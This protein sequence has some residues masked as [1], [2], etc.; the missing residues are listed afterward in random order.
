MET[1]SADAGEPRPEPEA[2]PPESEAAPAPEAG[3]APAPLPSPPTAPQTA[4]SNLY[5]DPR[6]AGWFQSLTIAS[7]A[8]GQYAYALTI[9][10]NI[11]TTLTPMTFSKPLFDGIQWDFA[12]DK[13]TATLLLSRI[14]DAGVSGANPQQ[15]TDNTNLIG[16]RLV[17]QV[18]DFVKVGGTFVSA[19]HAHTQV[20][21]FSGDMFK[22]NLTT[23]QNEIGRAHV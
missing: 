3:A 13:Y 8:K 18:G 12:S 21:A 15:R 6:F 5:K 10:D 4:G 1:A 22:G 19:H 2:P 14:S 7:D 11:R 17:A 16:G 9:G 20:E 23:Q